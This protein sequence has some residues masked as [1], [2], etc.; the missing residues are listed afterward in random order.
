MQTFQCAE[1]GQVLFFENTSCIRCGHALGFSPE[2]GY[3]LTLEPVEELATAPPGVSE[4]SGT[5]EVPATCYLSKTTS[6]ERFR[7]CANTA[8]YNACNWLIP[9]DSPNEY[10]LSCRLTEVLPPLSDEISRKQWVAV[11][12]AKRRLIYTLLGLGLPLR[13]REDDPELGLAFRLERSSDEHPVLT[14]HASGLITLN[15]AEA[16][17]A[18]RENAREKMGEA[19]RT[20]LGHLRHEC[21]HYYW[22]LLVLP[23]ESIVSRAREL[24]GDE[25]ASYEDAI[26]AH[27]SNGPPADWNLRFISAYASMHPWEDWAE[28]WAHYLHMVDTLETAE[29]YDLALRSPSSRGTTQRARPSLR[30]RHDFNRLFDGWYSLTFVLNG[31]TR[32]MGMPDAYP[33]VISEAVREKLRFVHEFVTE[34]A[35]KAPV[36]AA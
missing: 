11:E 5:S 1:C 12:A 7:Y 20:I 10:C 17:A 9:F 18:F 2:A 21:G 35:G 3:L 34:T 15:M 14:G 27:Y 32:S 13:A 8:K 23:S 24:F 26:I 30:E 6:T 4:P 22:E 36:E 19:Y 31:L 28:T 16:D 29:S 33:F 25:R